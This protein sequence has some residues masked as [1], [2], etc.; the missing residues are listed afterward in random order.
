MPKKQYIW[1]DGKMAESRHSNVHVLTHSLQYG[2]GIFEGIRAYQTSAGPAIFR[3]K[4]HAKRFLNSAKI[5][6]MNLGLAQA[7]IEEAVKSVVRKNGI[8]SGYI[9]PFAFYNDSRI[10]LSTLGK[11]VSVAV[12]AIEFGSYF[13][14]KDKGV[15]CKVSSWH[16]PN[17]MILPVEA[18]LSGNYANS[19]LASLEAKLAG[20]DEAIMLSSNGYVAEGPGENIF[21]V[22]DGALVTPSK[23]SD[24]LLGIT[25]DSILKIAKQKGLPVE[26]RP[27]HREELYSCDEA[28]FTGTAAEIT[29]IVSIDSRQIGSGRPGAM[30][31]ALWDAFSAI[32]HGNDPLYKGWLEYL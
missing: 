1:I 25:R 29:P 26:E 20:F 19:I 23:D 13:D 4:D 21:L 10:G 30:T 31:K 15:R 11:K 22:R 6:G 17:S 7:D 18:K 16:R 9:R 3:L 32:V 28:F 14:N 27:V 2:S 24:I 12:A 8:A 5:A